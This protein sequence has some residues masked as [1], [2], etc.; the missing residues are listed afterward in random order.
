MQHSTRGATCAARCAT[1][2]VRRVAYNVHLHCRARVE[3]HT[4]R[5]DRYAHHT[6]AI[7]RRASCAVDHPPCMS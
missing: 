2:A 4:P 7:V 6:S 3:L 5:A 1:S